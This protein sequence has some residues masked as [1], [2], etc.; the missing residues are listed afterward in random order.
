[1]ITIKKKQNKI[2]RVFNL[3]NYAAETG[4]PFSKFSNDYITSNESRINLNKLSE[5]KK[6]LKFMFMF[7]LDIYNRFFF[8][9]YHE[10]VYCWL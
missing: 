6:F 8:L 9:K 2:K 4:E 3:S 5:I 7:I 1:M 10:N